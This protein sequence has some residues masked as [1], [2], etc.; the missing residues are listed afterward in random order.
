MSRVDLNRNRV[1][2][3]HLNPDARQRDLEKFFREH[4][5]SH[6]KDI[7]VKV[8]YAF[9]EFD[10]KK[11]ADD[12]VYELDKR[13]FFGSRVTVEHAKGT[14]HDGEST[15]STSRDRDRRSHRS[16]S[17][18][19]SRGYRGNDRGHNRP[20]NTDWR[21]IVTNLSSRVGWHDLKDFFRAAGEVTFTKANKERINEGIVEFGSYKDMQ[22]AI[23]K[24][25][26]A[27]FFGRKLKLTDDSPGPPRSRSRSHGKRSRSRS[28]S[29][30]KKSQSSRHSRKRGSKSHS[31]S[32]SRSRSEERN[33]SASRSRSRS[34][35]PEQSPPR[36]DECNIGL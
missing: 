7:N 4:G 1:F 33:R 11:D 19:G 18:R 31:R 30:T 24:F 12:A 36:E 2:V 5:F 16:D 6:V 29:A 28:R 13:S 26:G 10:D 20:Y 27:E 21:I 32:K 14:P 17:H 9:V 22:H 25:D 8:G 3:G 15:G 34:K 35:S 23:K